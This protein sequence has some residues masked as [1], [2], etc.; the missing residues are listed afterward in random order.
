METINK[1]TK[2]TTQSLLVSSWKNVLADAE[3]IPKGVGWR[4][5]RETSDDSEV[6]IVTSA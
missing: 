5:Q 4:G 3:A 6:G 1:K 2:D